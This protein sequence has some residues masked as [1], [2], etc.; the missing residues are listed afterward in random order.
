MLHKDRDFWEEGIVVEPSWRTGNGAPV[1]T[2]MWEE[3]GAGR[4]DDRLPE[5]L[6]M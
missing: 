2:M 1:P 3:D 6:A 4:R 5:S